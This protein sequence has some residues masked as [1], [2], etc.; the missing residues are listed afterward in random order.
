[1]FS[2]VDIENITI[3]RD[4]VAASRMLGKKAPKTLYDFYKLF[5]EFEATYKLGTKV[6]CVH[7]INHGDYLICIAANR[8]FVVPRLRHFDIESIF[9]TEKK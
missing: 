5:T 6:G 3:K 4:F 8:R 7:F 2:G 9:A 1:M